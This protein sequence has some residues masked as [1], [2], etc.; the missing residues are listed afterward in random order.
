MPDRKG[1]ST[2]I[3]A[4]NLAAIT[5]ANLTEIGPSASIY[6]AL[7]LSRS[8]SCSAT[9]CMTGSPGAAAGSSWEC[10]SWLAA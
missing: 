8:T 7:G 4:V 9:C 10:W 1:A 5:A 3:V 6:T 2:A